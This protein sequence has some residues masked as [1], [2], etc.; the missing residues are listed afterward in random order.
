MDRPLLM[1]IVIAFLLILLALMVL[2]WRKRQRSQAAFPAPLALPENPGAETLAADAFYVAT[3]VAGEPLN[4][5]AVGGLGYRARATVGVL[6]HGLRLSIP[7]QPAIYIPAESIRTVERATWAIDRAVEQDG[8]ILIRWAL[9]E[10][11]D[12][13]REVDSYLRIIDPANAAQFFS[14]VQQLHS[15]TTQTAR[16]DQ[17]GGRAQ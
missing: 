17:T 6:E 2:G 9:G 8:L 5:I 12:A 1:A 4:R 11:A 15:G 10:T 3:T 14:S 7:G 13:R 16:T